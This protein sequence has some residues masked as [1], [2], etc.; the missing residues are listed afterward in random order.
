M[1]DHLRAYYHDPDLAEAIMHSAYLT[2][3]G[4][5]QLHGIVMLELFEHI[6]PLVG[7][8]EEFYRQQVMHM[9]RTL[10]IAVSATS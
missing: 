8:V 10:G 9:M 2:A 6:Q 5:P 1:Q 3:V 7:D 4:W